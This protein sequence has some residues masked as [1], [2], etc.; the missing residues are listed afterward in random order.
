VYPA[1]TSARGNLS[2]AEFGV[3]LVSR[4]LR[5][6]NPLSPHS[7]SSRTSEYAREERGDASAGRRRRSAVDDDDSQ[8]PSLAAL[9]DAIMP[10]GSMMYTYVK[11][12][13]AEK[14]QTLFRDLLD[15][16]AS[17]GDRAHAQREGK[18]NRDL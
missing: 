9:R 16:H 7:S 13:G 18:T 1:Y 5:G 8:R 17:E 6:D 12:H 4:L 2:I 3:E 14:A 11:Q 10:L 15:S